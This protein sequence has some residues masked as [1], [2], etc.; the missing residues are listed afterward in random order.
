MKCSSIK[1]SKNDD[2][3]SEFSEQ[4]YWA[5]NFG[6]KALQSRQNTRKTSNWQ[7]HQCYA[8]IINEYEH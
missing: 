1:G 2:L 4:N 3:L 5:Y 6:L 7:S 8:Y